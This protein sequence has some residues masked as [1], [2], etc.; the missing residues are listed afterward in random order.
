MTT[1]ARTK[2]NVR[3]IRGKKMY[4]VEKFLPPKCPKCNHK[5]KKQNDDWV[6]FLSENQGYDII[7]C[8]ECGNQTARFLLETYQVT[9][10]AFAEKLVAEAGFVNL[11][12]VRAFGNMTKEHHTI[13]AITP[14]MKTEFVRKT[15]KRK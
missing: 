6:I 15:K 5:F 9:N 8:A 11:I 12:E 7:V 13:V 2:S 1:K 14:N 4:L 3:K 10:K